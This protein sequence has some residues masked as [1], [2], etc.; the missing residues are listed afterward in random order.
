MV[1]R[2]VWWL[3]RK[4]NRTWPGASVGE[5]ISVVLGF[6]IVGNGFDVFAF[7][8]AGVVRGCDGKQEGRSQ[9]KTVSSRS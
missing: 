1:L 2:L 7:A 9:H 5:T 6:G 4:S 3:L 8:G